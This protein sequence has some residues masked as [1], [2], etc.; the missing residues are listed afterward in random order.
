[1]RP[2]LFYGSIVWWASLDKTYVHQVIRRVQRQATIAITRALRT[3][4]SDALDILLNLSPVDLFAQELA[5]NCAVSLRAISFFNCLQ[6]EHSTILVRA[7]C[8]NLTLDYCTPVQD[9][10]RNFKVIIP[11]KEDWTGFSFEK[12]P[13]RLLY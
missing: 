4:P 8:P 3:T 7:G 11:T 12:S 13:R 6:E 5:A 10:Q 9:F 1:M 2:I